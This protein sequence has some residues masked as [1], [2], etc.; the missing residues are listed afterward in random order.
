M[1]W[2]VVVLVLLVFAMLVGPV[3]MMKPSPRDRR[4]ANLR[5][6]ATNLG[7]RVSLQPLSKRMVAVYELPWEREEHTKLIGVEWML[8]RQSYS[9][10][11]HFADWWQWAGEGRP[12]AAAV[13]L[14]QAQMQSLPE[15][16]LAIEA[17]RL[18][19]RCYWSEIGGEQRLTLLG[20]W[21]KTTAAII[22]PYI[23]RP[24]M[25]VD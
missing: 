12:P 18:G 9:H 21:L 4:L 15:G 25:S 20:E 8:E 10:E 13:P 3:L 19:L 11:I 23:H 1:S 14:L 22:R 2:F 6:Q 7:L 24:K 16:V 17:T 5:S